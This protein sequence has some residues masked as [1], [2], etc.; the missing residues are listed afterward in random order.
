MILPI[1]NKLLNLSGKARVITAALSRR[2]SEGVWMFDAD[3]TTTFAN[4]MMAEML[5]YTVEEMLGRSL[6]EFID[7]DSREIA[8]SYVQRRRQGIR[9]TPRF[10]SFTRKDGS[11][12]WA[13]VSATPMFD[14]EGEFAGV[15]RMITDISDR[16]TSRS[17][18][19]QNSPRIRI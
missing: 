6:F 19:A 13:I 9:E 17:R 2:L 16:K 4:S 3:S 10:F 11:H 15:L 5:G 18:I 12:L 7:D 8:E 14:A 1:A